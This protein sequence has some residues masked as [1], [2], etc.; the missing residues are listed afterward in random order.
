VKSWDC[1]PPTCRLNAI[2]LVPSGGRDVDGLGDGEVVE[3]L[4]D[5]DDV[6]GLGDGVAESSFLMRPLARDLPSLIPADGFDNS[7]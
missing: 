6:D 7:T 1:G 5:G 4:G 3:G 2:R